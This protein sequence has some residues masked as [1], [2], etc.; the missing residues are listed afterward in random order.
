MAKINLPTVPRK[1]VSK[2]PKRIIIFSKP[3]MG[4]T[5]TVSKLP[6]CLIVDC[7]KG[8]R[9]LTALT[10]EVDKISDI[11]DLV[12]SIVDYGIKNDGK[13]PYSFIAIDT[14]SALEEMCLPVA[15]HRYSLSPEGRQWFL[16][17]DGSDNA[18]VPLHEKSGKYQYGSLLNLPFGKGNIYVGQVFNELMAKLENVTPKLILL[19]HSVEKITKNKAGVESTVI[20]LMMSKQ[21]K[22]VSTFKADAIGYMYRKGK[23]NFIDFTATEEKGIGGRHRYLEKEHILISEYKDKEDGSEELITYWESIYS[24]KEQ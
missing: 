18:D 13:Y 5:T 3:K 9:A 12:E 4:K 15:E 21:C 2:T 14:A 8:T 1:A 7:E 17:V 10:Y 20:D 11:Y 16:R 24:P 23:Q 19:A 6:N 22:F